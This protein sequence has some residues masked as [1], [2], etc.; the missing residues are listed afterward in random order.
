MNSIKATLQQYLPPY[1]YDINTTTLI[2][3]NDY[4]INPDDKYNV[5]G[6]DA[7][8]FKS[9]MQAYG[10]VQPQANY[11][12]PVGDGCF[13]FNGNSCLFMD[14]S[15]PYQN[16]LIFTYEFFINTSNRSANQ[17]IFSKWSYNKYYGFKFGFI[18]NSTFGLAVYNTSSTAEWSFTTSTFP[19]AYKWSHVALCRNLNYFY[20]FINGVRVAYSQFDLNKPY[21]LCQNQNS[22]VI[23]SDYFTRG[24]FQGQLTEFRISNIC[25]YTSDFTPPTTRFNP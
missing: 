25:R 21:T 1:Q 6:V 20:L 7:S 10:Y 2:H 18:T 14:A 19:D 17:I 12:T 22:F 5:I 15:V 13:Y 8:M 23:G 3:C 24:R 16:D 4:I 9:S 11:S